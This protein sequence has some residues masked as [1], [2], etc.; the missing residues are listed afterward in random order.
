MSKNDQHNIHL[1]TSDKLKFKKLYNVSRETTN[2]LETYEE[3]LLHSNRQFNLIGSGT[4]KD[5]WSRH[6]ADS[7]KLF[8][9]S[10]NCFRK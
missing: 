5:I 2:I 1:D 8:F 3:W 9:C 7:A 4:E 10:V 6:F